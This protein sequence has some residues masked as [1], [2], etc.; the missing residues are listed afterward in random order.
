MEYKQVILVRTDIKMSKG[1][2]AAQVAHASIEATLKSD[3]QKVKAWRNKG[4]KK[5]VLKVKE[6]S[7]L[8]KFK[9]FAKDVGVVSALI[10]DAGKTQLDP[11]TITCLAI[12]PD[13]VKK[14]D[15]VSGDLKMM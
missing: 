4:M 15:S 1:K 13:E 14:V 12:G 2:T 7:E 10:R 11:G 3:D 8:F 6:E 9:E 5:V